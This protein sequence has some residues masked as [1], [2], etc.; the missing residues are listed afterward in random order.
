MDFYSDYLNSYKLSHLD[1]RKKLIELLTIFHLHKCHDI[2]C[3]YLII[4]MSVNP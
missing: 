2:A 1:Q 3:S 4:N